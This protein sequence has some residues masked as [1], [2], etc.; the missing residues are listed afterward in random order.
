MRKP[1]FIFT[2]FLLPLF[3]KAQTFSSNLPLIIINTT[4]TDEIYDEPR[5]P[6]LM[7]IIDNGQGQLNTTTD[8]F[9]GYDGHIAIEIRGASSQGFPKKNYGFETQ[10]LAASIRTTNHVSECALIGADVIT[11]PPSVIK[12]LAMHPLTD[13]GLD[14]FMKDWEKTGQK[15]L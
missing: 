3:S 1:V 14:Q 2:L 6:A 4:D 11:A 15:I 10:I 7:G 9:N 5:V 13:K 12:S 8:P